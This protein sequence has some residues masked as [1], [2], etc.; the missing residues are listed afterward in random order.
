MRLEMSWGKGVLLLGSLIGLG[1]LGYFVFRVKDETSEEVEVSAA[2][3]SVAKK[4]FRSIKSELDQ[5]ASAIQQ[6]SAEA[7][8]KTDKVPLE[9]NDDFPLKLG[10]KGQRV[11]QLQMYLLR[12]HG[13]QRIVDD[14]YDLAL[15]Q[16]VEKYL[17]VTSV[18][19][20]QFKALNIAGDTKTK[21]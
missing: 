15:R 16:S 3:P 19:A 6:K 7:V 17:N 11:R 1:A 2:E 20:Q 13:N 14:V 5:R 9:V 21:R 10:S 4:P 12:N 18:S 8:I